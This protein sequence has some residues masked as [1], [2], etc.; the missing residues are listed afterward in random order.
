MYLALA[1][2][3]LA[4]AITGGENRGATL[5]HDHVVRAFAG[6]F[7]L[8]HA[9]ADLEVPAGVRRDHAHAVAFVQDERSGDVVQVVRVPLAQCAR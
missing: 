8:G 9:D 1:E 4:N 2:D 6:P 7:P 5:A 3:G